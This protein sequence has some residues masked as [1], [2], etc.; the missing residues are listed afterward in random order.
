MNSSKTISVK[1]EKGLVRD[2]K[3]K[4]KGKDPLS[5]LRTVLGY[6]AIIQRRQLSKQRY[7]RG[8]NEVSVAFESPSLAKNVFIKQFD[9]D[10][11]HSES[12]YEKIKDKVIPIKKQTTETKSTKKID[13]NV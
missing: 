4:E 10:W 2:Y 1:D 9:M 11:D 3:Y 7:S 8:N 12:E 5:E 13:V 6:Y